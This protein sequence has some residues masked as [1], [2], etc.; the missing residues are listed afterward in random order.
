LKLSAWQT[1]YL[2]LRRDEISEG[3]E[4]A[5]RQTF[6]AL[7]ACLGDVVVSR[8]TADHARKFRRQLRGRGLDGN[9]HLRDARCIW[10]WA[11]REG[12]A[13]TNVFSGLP[14]SRAPGPFRYVSVDELAALRAVA[15][16]WR[17]LIGVCRLAGL[18]RGEALRAQWGDL[19]AD[20][21][22]R[23]MLNVYAPKTDRSRVVPVVPELR[24]ELHPLRACPYICRVPSNNLK[25]DANAIIV[26]AGL[27][28]WG[29][30]FQ[31]L[32]KSCESDWL[33]RYPVMDVAGWMGHSPSVSQRYYHQTTERVW[34][35]VAKGSS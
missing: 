23:S 10:G 21:A 25:R 14:K 16:S 32:R 15:G 17:V 12:V 31:S 34:D 28:P 26:R 7:R 20:R 30:F 9:R 29:A 33:A 2:D 6:R 3:T 1:R 18:R 5:Y 24:A 22:G 27:E 11:V 4:L 19:V 35:D 8:V 13:G